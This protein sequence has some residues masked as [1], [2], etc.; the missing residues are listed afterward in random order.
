VP[1]CQSKQTLCGEEFWGEMKKK[2]PNVLKWKKRREKTFTFLHVDRYVYIF[3]FSDDN[4]IPKIK[5]LHQKK[6]TLLHKR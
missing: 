1:C 3:P 6:I 4:R 2:K 5:M